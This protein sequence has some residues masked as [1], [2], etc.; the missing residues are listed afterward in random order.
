MM[1]NKN[2]DE[3]KDNSTKKILETGIQSDDKLQKQIYHY[4]TQMIKTEVNEKVNNYLNIMLNKDL[5]TN[6]TDDTVNFANTDLNVDDYNSIKGRNDIHYDN[7]N[8]ENSYANSIT[9]SNIDFSQYKMKTILESIINK[10]NLNKTK[11]AEGLGINRATLNNIIKDPNS[12][13]LLNAYKLSKLFNMPV[14]DLFR[15][16]L[17]KNIESDKNI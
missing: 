12:C 15:L 3:F 8:E 7:Y 14:E 13:S 6:D 5:D 2:D 17:I 9:Y 11:L 10:Y 1:S 16:T 4:I